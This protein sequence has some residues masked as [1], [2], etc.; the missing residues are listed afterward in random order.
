MN[1]YVHY[2]KTHYKEEKPEGT[3]CG[4]K[5]TMFRYKEQMEEDFEM[6]KDLYRDSEDFKDFNHWFS[7]SY[8][9]RTGKDTGFKVSF[10]ISMGSTPS[11]QEHYF[12]PYLI[13]EQ[14]DE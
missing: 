2:I 14:E 3:Y 6:L 5:I 1:N 12:G 8:Y 4:G 10:S 13:K 9:V 11:G 7:S